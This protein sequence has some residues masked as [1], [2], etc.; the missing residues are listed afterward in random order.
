MVT[1][2]LPRTL[3]GTAEQQQRIPLDLGPAATVAGLLDQLGARYPL[4]GR[5]IRDETGAVRRY[6]NL[7][8][9]G[10]DVRGL[11]GPATVVRDG[12]ELR[13]VQSVAGG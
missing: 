10:E 11:A 2:L 4:L 12:Q 5:R 1:V 6:V 3:A 8:L 9:D 7:Y 13:V